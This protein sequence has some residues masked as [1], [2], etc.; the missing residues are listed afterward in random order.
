MDA[1]VD[2]KE[3]EDNPT[4]AQD[5]KR[6]ILEERQKEQQIY[7]SLP[8]TL[9]CGLFEISMSE[10]RSLFARQHGSIAQALLQLLERRY[11]D[12]SET[13]LS[14]Y[15]K[16]KVMLRKPRKNIEELTELK[17]YMDMLPELLTKLAGEGAKVYEVYGILA[18]DFKLRLPQDM[19]ELKWHCYR[20]SKDIIECMAEVKAY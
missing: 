20:G 11:R 17:E 9:N 2:S 1:I 3:D 14:E 6:E 18:D 10:A 12:M 8:D 16:I 4:S 7:D 15:G 13:L 5:I 19:V